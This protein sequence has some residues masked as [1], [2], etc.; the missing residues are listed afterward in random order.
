[1]KTTVYAIGVS[2]IALLMSSCG[3][4]GG[5]GGGSPAP[6]PTWL[7]M[8]YIAADNNLEVQVAD[9]VNLMEVAPAST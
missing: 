5:G 9:D 4:G 3:G 6:A 2:V 1:M 8:V 7:V